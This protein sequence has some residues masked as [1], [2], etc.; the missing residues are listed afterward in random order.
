[1]ANSNQTIFQRLSN[2]FRGGSSSA[3]AEIITT[4]SSRRGV[5]NDILFTTSD[6][7]E[8]ERKLKTY[9]Q[10]KYLSYQ[11]QKAQ[12]DNSM[13]SLAGYT[14]VKLMYRDVDLMDG[15]PEIGTALDIISEEACPLTSKGKMINIHSNSKRIKSILEDLFI[16]RLHIYTDLPMIARHLAKYG[17]TFMLLNIDA[18]NGIM[19]W[20]MLPVYEIDRI[21]NGHLSVYGKSVNMNSGAND[22]VPNKVQ[23]V[24][25]NKNESQP[26]FNWQVAHFR[27]LN[28]SFFLP[29]GVS[30]LHKA[31]RTWRMWS[32]MEDAMLIWRLDKAVE[33]RVFKI[34][35]GGI[36][37]EDV[38]AYVQEIANNFKRTQIIDPATGQIDLR[39][40]FLD[41][42]SDFFIP[43]RREDAP[44]PID[45]LAGANSQVQMEDIEY[46]QNKMFAAMRVP[47]T[48]L[49]FQEAQGKGQDLSIMDR[50]FSRMINRIQQFLL[51]ELNKIAMIHLN[52]MGLA[53]EMSNFTISLNNPSSQIES[54]E[55]DDLNKRLQ[56]MQ[57]ALADPGTGIPMMSIHRALKEIMKM[58]DTEIKDMLTEIRL[59]KAMAAEL[60]ATA[61]IIKKTG[62]FDSVDRIYGDY[63]AMNNPQAQ[64]AQ[65]EGDEEGLGGGGGGF[66]GGDFGGDMDMDLGEPGSSDEGDLGGD[67]GE[68][69]MDNAPGADVGEPLM[70]NSD[71]RLR[72]ITEK[73]KRDSFK[74][75]KTFTKRYFDMLEESLRDEQE[76]FNKSELFNEQIVTINHTINEI[77]ENIDSLVNEEEFKNECLID[78]VINDTKILEE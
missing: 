22:I 1:M 55:L 17:N 41:V 5:N 14:A 45:T 57:T 40:N 26:Y 61:N 29:Y 12:I 63:E 66:G 27:L 48:F 36:N 33:R 32:M 68:T 70:E 76:V 25:M 53:D 20:T 10:Q 56:A 60:A 11:W 21:E 74:P 49:N 30:M 62:I 59:E 71:R 77:Y 35:V 42:S 7:A 72:M 46:M 39:K 69:D 15:T 9:Q 34:Y 19:G 6:K 65:A 13:E 54:L 43:V 23:F 75:I 8:Y 50:R 58:S 3:P 73:K 28:D 2:V 51:M 4:P 31:R 47:K 24:W 38:P 44:T 18:N 37:D 78:E 52:M 16:N 67:M 64:Q